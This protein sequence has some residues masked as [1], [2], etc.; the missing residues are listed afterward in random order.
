MYFERE[1]WQYMREL[2]VAEKYVSVNCDL[3]VPD[4]MCGLDICS[5]EIV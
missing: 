2:G 3:D 1:R 5:V 4:V